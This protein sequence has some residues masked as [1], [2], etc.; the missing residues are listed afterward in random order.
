MPSDVAADVIANIPLS[1]D[2]NVLQL[3]APAIAAAAT[4]GQFVMVKVATGHDPLLRRPFSVFEVLRDRAGR[5]IGISIL[6]KRIG[7]STRLVYSAR[8]GQRVSCLGP[9]GRPFSLVEP[10]TEAWM[11]AGG[12]GL[13]PFL[14][15]TETLAARGVPTTLFYGARRA[16]ELFYLD[17]FRQ[18]GARLVL[19]TE[20]GSAGEAGRI[21]A[22][23]ER[24]LAAATNRRVALYACGPEGMLA[25]TARVAE[26]FARPCQVSVER[27]MGCGM[28]GCYS[29][30]VPMKNEQGTAHHVRSCIAG[31]VL[32]ADRIVWD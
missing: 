13:A 29:C 31:P 26:R 9:L 25:A 7:V 1:N 27:T 16:S 20:D 22:P 15:L 30:V 8:E 11:V 6:N 4:P 24:E 28:G 19:T 21:I 12:V 18:L 17:T 14:A 23:L 32:D 5:H 10:P 2:Y 3:A